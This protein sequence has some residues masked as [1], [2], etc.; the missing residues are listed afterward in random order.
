MSVHAISA[1]LKHSRARLGDRLV[2][3]VLADH[4]DAN[5]GNSFPSLPLIAAEALMSTRQVR[6]ALQKLEGTEKFEAEIEAVGT[7]ESGVTI[8]QI[9]LPGVTGSHESVTNP[10]SAPLKE[11]STNHQGEQ[12]LFSEEENPSAEGETELSSAARRI[13]EHWDSVMPSSGTRRYTESRA[14]KI[15]ARLKEGYTEDDCRRAID[16]CASSDFHMG[17]DPGNGGQVHNGIDLIFRNGEKLEG[18][19]DR[20]PARKVIG[21]EELAALRESYHE[22]EVEDLRSEDKYPFD[23]ESDRRIAEAGLEA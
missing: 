10:T 23:A 9:L 21:L 18:F 20:V 5:G 4:A 1:V 11:P 6:R 16:G 2:M 22:V 12:P 7:T 14:K 8:W 15:I 17:R 3:L 19:R 13:F